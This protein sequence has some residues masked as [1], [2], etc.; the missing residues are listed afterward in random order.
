MKLAVLIAWIIVFISDITCAVAGATP[1]WFMV[2]APLIVI[3]ARYGVDVAE[4]YMNK[5]DKGS[6]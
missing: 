5:K 4:E 6:H 1:D 2:F 3:I